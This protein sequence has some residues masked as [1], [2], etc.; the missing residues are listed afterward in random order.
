MRAA[1]AVLLV[2]AIGTGV[3]TACAEDENEKQ[4]VTIIELGASSEWE[5]HGAPSFGPSAAIEFNPIKNLEIEAGISPLFDSQ[6]RTDW[7]FELMFRRPFDLSKT[8][9]LEPG[10]GPA[11]N[12]FGQVGLTASAELMMWPWPDR[13]LGL[14]ID[15]GYTVSLAAGHTQSVG[16][17]VG[18]LIPIFR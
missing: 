12:G 2:T 18:M 16:L 10:I 7:D 17:T 4:P 3:E 5:L 8:F 9:E 11:L 15:P 6:H 14:F 1:F 13:K